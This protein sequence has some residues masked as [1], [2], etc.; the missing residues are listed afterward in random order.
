[1]EQRPVGFLLREWRQRRRWSQLQLATEAD[2]SARHLSFVETGR[3][4]PTS[5]MILH[6]SE[7]L[8]IPLRERN[9]LLL[10]GGFAPAYPA[11]GL[12][13]P[14]MDAVCAAL[15]RVLAGQAPCPALAV[16]RQW[17]LV[18][19]NATVPLFLD[20]ADADLVR[21]PVNVLRLSLHP[22]GMAPRIANLGE[23]RSHV[24]ARLRRQIDAT[25]D[26]DLLALHRELR[27][28]PASES[29]VDHVP[30]G[31][32]VVPLRYRFGDQELSLFSTTTV[33]G[34]PMDV[35]VAE[36]AIESFY[37]ADE[38]TMDFLGRYV[39]GRPPR[40]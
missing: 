3:A 6:L 17:N 20:G 2:I 31:S 24:L 28:Y 4:R 14:G 36:L 12:D 8:G 39:D 21:P 40:R 1:M 13:A 26:A 11:R 10:A 9:A 23:W 27:D 37:P 33:F 38:S 5:T 16:D 25:A 30:D 22:R 18:D 19:S 35:T 7:H 32:V 15:R 34:T 29:D